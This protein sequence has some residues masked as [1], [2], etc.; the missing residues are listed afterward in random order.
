MPG[1]AKRRA[2]YLAKMRRKQENIERNRNAKNKKIER[3]AKRKE[4]KKIERKM[5]QKKKEKE[6]KEIEIRK[7]DDSSGFT[8]RKLRLRSDVHQQFQPDHPLNNSDQ[9]DSAL[10]LPQKPITRNPAAMP[11]KIPT[12]ASIPSILSKKDATPNNNNYLRSYREGGQRIGSSSESTL[13][14]P[15]L[16]VVVLYNDRSIRSTCNDMLCYDV[17]SYIDIPSCFFFFVVYI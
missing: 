17:I 12:T 7:K 16:L 14:V 11:H 8:P 6:E 10:P 4:D 1:K 2:K 15:L 3:K 5:K 13:E 9:N